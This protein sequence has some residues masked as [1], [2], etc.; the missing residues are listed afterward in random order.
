MLLPS[1]MAPKIVR[2]NC[3]LARNALVLEGCWS[4]YIIYL[5]T[6]DIAMPLCLE[7]AFF[8]GPHMECRPLLFLLLA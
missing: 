8:T 1:D 4:D 5:Y 3:S 7:A 2:V 6:P